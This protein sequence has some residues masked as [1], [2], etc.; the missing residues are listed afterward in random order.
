MNKN[1]Q[2]EIL[3]NVFIQVRNEKTNRLIKEVKTKNNVTKTALLG[4]AN[5]LCDTYIMNV[6]NEMTNA[7]PNYLAYGTGK[8]PASFNTSAL[9]TEISD[10][11]IEIARKI[12]NS[13][14]GDFIQITMKSYISS[15]VIIPE[16][17]ITELGLFTQNTG[18][19]CWAKVIL[20]EPITKSNTQ[21]IDII[22]YIKIKPYTE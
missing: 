6:N 12:I 14:L 5:F 16:E 17:G 8:T 18:S 15:G 4:I 10:P 20:P 2:L 11:R 3:S 13:T 1:A 7:I 22:W 9:G 21:I 19:N